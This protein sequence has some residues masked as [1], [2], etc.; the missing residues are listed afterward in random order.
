MF[1]DVGSHSTLQWRIFSYQKIQLKHCFPFYLHICEVDSLHIFSQKQHIDK[2]NTKA[3]Q[4]LQFSSIKNIKNN[5]KN[6]K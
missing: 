4:R 2:P 3:D 6:V 1:T 5:C